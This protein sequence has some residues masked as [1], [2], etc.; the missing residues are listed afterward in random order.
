M[1]GHKKKG[2]QAMPSPFV[3]PVLF[4]YLYALCIALGRLVLVPDHELQF[5]LGHVFDRE[6]TGETVD[7]QLLQCAVRRVAQGN[8]YGA[9]DVFRYRYGVDSL[10][11]CICNAKL[12]LR[13][14]LG[15]GILRQGYF[16]LV[17]P[18]YRY[19]LRAAAVVGKGYR[20]PYISRFL[21]A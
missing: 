4:V 5:G 13:L 3:C 15:F 20:Q 1:I 12:G 7:A 6:F 18:L 2:R 21:H 8:V 16:K 14:G 9:P 11:V 10:A 19:V 17:R